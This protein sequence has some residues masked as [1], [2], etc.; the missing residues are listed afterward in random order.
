MKKIL[1]M[2]LLC[3]LI[4]G[5]LGSF[6][7]ISAANTT[8]PYSGG[9]GTEDDP[10][11]IS[12]ADDIKELRSNI[13]SDPSLYSKKVCYKLT[14]DITLNSPISP[15]F[16]VEGEGMHCFVQSKYYGQIIDLFYSAYK[17]ED[18]DEFDRAYEELMT[19]TGP[20]SRWIRY[21]SR[22]VNEYMGTYYISQDN[23]EDLFWDAAS[24]ETFESVL[25]VQSYYYYREAV[26][27]GVFDGDGHTIYVNNSNVFGFVKNGAEIKNLTVSGRNASLA[28][29]VGEDSRVSNCTFKINGSHEL[30]YIGEITIGWDYEGN[31]PYLVEH[32]LTENGLIH[33]NYGTISGCENYYN[34]KLAGCD[35][36]VWEDFVSY[37]C[38][39]KNELNGVNFQRS[40]NLGGSTEVVSDG[41]YS[42]EECLAAGGDPSAF[43]GFDFINTWIMIDGMPQLRHAVEIEVCGDID[44]NGRLDGIDANI[45]C[46]YLGGQTAGMYYYLPEAADMNG[47]KRLDA[48]D[49]Y[50]LKKTL[51]GN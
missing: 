2:M 47:D 37:T 12:T 17:N 14:N 6:S 44:L 16:F 26:F 1:S 35:N 40:L 27:S 31:F 5:T 30:S 32:T 3:A 11:L 38:L 28:Y 25:D 50:L 7:Y 41:I 23:G 34:V 36:G 45:F 24:V 49:S 8:S 21:Y 10:Y 19:E 46:R 33:N 51:S 4:L 20:L 18:P 42:E 48:A 13:E 43:E 15:I 39:S 9:S 29:Y 22:D